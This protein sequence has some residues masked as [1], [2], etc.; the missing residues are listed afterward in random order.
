MIKFLNGNLAETRPNQTITYSSKSLS[1]NG[2][3]E[4]AFA[5]QFTS[6]VPHSSDPS[7]RIVKRRLLTEFPLDSSVLRFSPDIVSQAVKTTR[8]LVP[9][10]QLT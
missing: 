6:H 8:I 4:T 9:L 5:K 10:D 1:R 3:I 7:V 2:E